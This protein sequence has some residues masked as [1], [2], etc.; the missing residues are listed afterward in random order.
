MSEHDKITMEL[1]IVGFIALSAIGLG[2]IFYH[3]VEKLSWLDSAYF[4]VITL[5]TVGF[6]DITP[7]TDLGKV[8]TIFYVIVGIGIIGA[9]ANL[10]LR[11][12]ALRHV[13]R[14]NKK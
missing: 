14:N 2:A 7:H 11:R 9:L 1:R 12:A 6:G 4:T 5:A 3:K 13:E 10:L 8:F